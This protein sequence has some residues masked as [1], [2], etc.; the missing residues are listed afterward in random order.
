M[1]STCG[2][3]TI[4]CGHGGDICNILALKTLIVGLYLLKLW[5]RI[6][7]YSSNHAL[8]LDVIFFVIQISF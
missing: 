6:L 2:V 1:T 3:Y 5:G 4:A 7:F 8:C